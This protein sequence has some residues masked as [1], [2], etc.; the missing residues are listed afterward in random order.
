MKERRCRN[1]DPSRSS[2][3]TPPR[4][5]AT[6]VRKGPHFPGPGLDSGWHRACWMLPRPMAPSIDDLL[7]DD[8]DHLHAVLNR[9]RKG[10]SEEDAHLPDLIGEFSDDLKR[11]IA[12]EEE[13]LFPA[14]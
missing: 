4:N 11:H 14:L 13:A 9:I 12:F 7:R 3:A 2:K 10:M 5:S 8:H 6:G 1:W